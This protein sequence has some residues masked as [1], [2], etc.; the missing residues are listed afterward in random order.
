MIPSNQIFRNNS[1]NIAMSTDTGIIF[2]VKSV[3]GNWKWP[4]MN[5]AL[6]QDFLLCYFMFGMGLC[7][8]E[9]SISVGSKAH[10]LFE[11]AFKSQGMSILGD[12]TTSHI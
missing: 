2:E 6:W 11:G 9:A 10:Q 4:G 3:E 8:E 7:S 12:L 1:E 5:W